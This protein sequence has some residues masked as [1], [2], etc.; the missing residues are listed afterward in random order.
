MQGMIKAGQIV[1]VCMCIQ[2]VSDETD[3]IRTSPNKKKTCPLPN[4]S[5]S[6]MMHK[7]FD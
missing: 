3:H 6:H 5:P 2:L 4:R 1:A 7:R